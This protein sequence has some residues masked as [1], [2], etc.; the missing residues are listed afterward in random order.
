MMLSDV[1]AR[2]A[3]SA[4]VSCNVSDT[5]GILTRSVRTEEVPFTSFARISKLV[6]E[7]LRS[8]RKGFA[9]IQALIS[10]AFFA[11]ALATSSAKQ[12]VNALV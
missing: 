12:K 6:I 3:L 7:A 2:R 4:T 10:V 8:L 9:T 1:F 5:F 11:V